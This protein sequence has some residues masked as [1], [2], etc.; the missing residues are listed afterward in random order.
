VTRVS[1]IES[2]RGKEADKYTV[3][4]SYTTKTSAKKSVGGSISLSLAKS[5]FTGGLG[6]DIS[7]EWGWEQSRTEEHRREVSIPSCTQVHLTFQPFQRTV[8]VNPIFY[9]A[10]Y[11][12]DKGN[13]D[14]ATV[15]TWRGRGAGWKTIYSYGYYIDGISDVLLSDGRIDGIRD[16]V[17]Q[18][19]PADT[20][21]R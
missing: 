2:N 4:G 7:Y 10:E 18:N 8:R 1:N 14:K 12:W 6:G 19:L 20:C 16:K 9:V 21:N 17:E 15:D 11:S 13:G 5:I 3:V